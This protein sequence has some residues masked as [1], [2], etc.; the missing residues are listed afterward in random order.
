[1]GW[2]A[3]AAVAA[4]TVSGA[5]ASATAAVG[6][7]ADAPVPT[8]S[9]TV[10]GSSDGRVFDGIGAISGGGATSRLLLDYPEKQRSEVLVYLF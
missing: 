1:V 6:T 10:D 2:I 4:M 8:S 7:D 5:A 9:I 3:V